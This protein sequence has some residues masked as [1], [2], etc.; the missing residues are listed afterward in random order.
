M[1][2]IERTV[3]ENVVFFIYKTRQEKGCRR[4]GKRSEGTKKEGGC[5][6]DFFAHTME[7]E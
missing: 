1:L 3:G 4:A 6:C 5:V 7:K 2:K